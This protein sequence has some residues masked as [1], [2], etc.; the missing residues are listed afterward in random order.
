MGTRHRHPR[1]VVHWAAL[2]CI[3]TNV[4]QGLSVG[5]GFASRRVVQAAPLAAILASVARGLAVWVGFAG[6]GYGPNQ[7]GACGQRANQNND[8]GTFAPCRSRC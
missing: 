6:G 7:L 3:L 5:V 4:A 2:A 1:R 8:Y